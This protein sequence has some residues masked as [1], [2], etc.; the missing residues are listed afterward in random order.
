MELE[1]WLTT[2]LK[3]TWLIV[4][5]IIVVSSVLQIFQEHNMNL[6]SLLWSVALIEAIIIMTVYIVSLVSQ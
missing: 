5:I 6:N 3:I 1:P 4:G 2:A